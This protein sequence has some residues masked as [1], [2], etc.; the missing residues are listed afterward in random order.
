[1]VID[2][3]PGCVRPWF[4]GRSVKEMQRH[5]RVKFTVILEQQLSFN[6]IKWSAHLISS[7][8]NL[9]QIEISNNITNQCW[10]N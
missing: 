2:A 1:M 10:T 3:I 8:T 4:N 6:N 7:A 5:L 9:R